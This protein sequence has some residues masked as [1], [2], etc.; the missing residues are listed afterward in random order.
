MAWFCQKHIAVIGFYCTH[1]VTRPGP[2]RQGT[3]TKTEAD[4]VGSEK[5]P[6]AH[7]EGD[8]T[9]D[10]QKVS[11]VLRLIHEYKIKQQGRK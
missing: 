5:D 2:Y 3:H 4:C 7:T 10:K 6:T 8:G 1:I 11:R 9:K